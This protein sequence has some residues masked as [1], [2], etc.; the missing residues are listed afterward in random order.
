MRTLPTGGKYLA[1]KTHIL[2]KYSESTQEKLNRLLANCKLGN[3]MPSELFAEMQARA[4]GLFSHNALLLMWYR[5]LPN[6]IALHLDDEVSQMDPSRATEKADRL[7]ERTKDRLNNADNLQVFA[8]NPSSLSSAT[9]LS[10]LA[11]TIAALQSQLSSRQSRSSQRNDQN[12]RSRSRSKS[13]SK[14]KT[15]FGPN[16]DL[17]YFYYKF[18][19]KARKCQGSCAWKDDAASTSET[20]NQGNQYAQK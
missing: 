7:F 8:Q 1:L 12:G 19:N 20:T 14:S 18:K 10:Q 17:C 3:R 15:R 16:R 2:K 4:K 6:E 13:R 9:D 5:Q 11:A